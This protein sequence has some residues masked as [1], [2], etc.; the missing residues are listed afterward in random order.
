MI[1]VELWNEYGP[2][3]M[4]CGRHSRSRFDPETFRELHTVPIGRPGLH[5][6][7]QIWQ[8]QTG[9]WWKGKSFGM[10]TRIKI[11]K[12]ERVIWY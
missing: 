9:N 10:D 6:F 7:T 11:E 2:T 12:D 5:S 8:D 3:R 1:Y 4:H